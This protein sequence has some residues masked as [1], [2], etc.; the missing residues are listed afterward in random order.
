[1]ASFTWV[2]PEHPEQSP[3]G[4][5]VLSSGQYSF[6]PF[7]WQLAGECAGGGLTQ[8]LPLVEVLPEQ[9]LQELL[10]HAIIK[11]PMVGSVGLVGAFLQ[12]ML[13]AY[14]PLEQYFFPEQ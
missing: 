8:V 12:L 5:H 9:V 2:F 7:A 10:Q 13:P 4:L 6:P 11:L 1:M 3:S 14:C